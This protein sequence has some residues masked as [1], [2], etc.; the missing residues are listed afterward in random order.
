[1]DPTQLRTLVTF[2]FPA[3][4]GTT[5]LALSVLT[6][7]TRRH[8]QQFINLELRIGAIEAGPRLSPPAPVPLPVYQAHV[9]SPSAPP[10]AD[11]GPIALAVPAY[12][13]VQTAQGPR[14][15]GYI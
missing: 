10:A 9:P 14:Y 5:L 12:Q 7:R 4:F 8:N 6:C 13:V 15:T 3:L 11:P 2:V 1:M